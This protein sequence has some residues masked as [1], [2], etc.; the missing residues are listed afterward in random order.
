MLRSVFRN[1][2]A[3]SQWIYAGF[4]NRLTKWRGVV[5]GRALLFRQSQRLISQSR[6][7]DGRRKGLQRTGA[8]EV[9]AELG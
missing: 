1:A 5:P 9:V 3:A 8:N 7:G 4:L 6:S 2:R